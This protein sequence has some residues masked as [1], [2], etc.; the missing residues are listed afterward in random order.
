MQ[1][2]A[3]P[4]DGQAD[5]DELPEPSVSREE[6]LYRYL[7][8]LGTTPADYYSLLNLPRT[9]RAPPLAHHPQHVGGG[10]AEA[11]PFGE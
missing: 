4:F 3:N 2:A 6:Q 11:L 7:K 9:V 8:E 5:D 1:R 10:V